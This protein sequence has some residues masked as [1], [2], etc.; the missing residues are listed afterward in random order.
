MSRYIEKT[1]LWVLM[2]LSFEELVKYNSIFWTSVLVSWLLAANSWGAK[3]QHHLP[4]PS[5]REGPGLMIDL[6]SN[7]SHGPGPETGDIIYY[8]NHFLSA[9]NRISGE[10]FILLTWPGHNHVPDNQ[11][12]NCSQ[13]MLWDY[14]KTL[15]V[16]V[17]LSCDE[18]RTLKVCSVSQIQRRRSFLWHCIAI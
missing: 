9:S 2:E 14:L 5:V 11:T 16:E 10:F 8:A 7:V 1:Y 12:E 13:L 6:C 18:G 4:S 15:C 3:S 17:R